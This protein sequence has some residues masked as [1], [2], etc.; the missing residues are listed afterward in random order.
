[1]SVSCRFNLFKTLLRSKNNTNICV[2]GP[3]T[4]AGYD[5]SVMSIRALIRGLKTKDVKEPDITTITKEVNVP[6]NFQTLD[7]Y[8]CASECQRRKTC[9]H[10]SC[11]TNTTYICIQT[12]RETHLETKQLCSTHYRQ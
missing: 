8:I 2:S 3:Q 11:K 7:P 10:G 5:K 1:M 4:G 9:T 12:V 6:K